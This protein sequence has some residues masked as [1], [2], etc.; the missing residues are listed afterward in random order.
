MDI[1]I[2]T[3]KWGTKYGP[4]YTNRLFHSLVSHIDVPF[5]FTCITDDARGLEQK[6]QIIDYNTWDPFDYPKD[7]V[8]TREKVVL[9]DRMT[10][11]NNFWIDQDILIHNNITDLVTRQLDVPTFI[12]NYWNW[13]HKTE[14]DRLKWF[15]KLTQCYVNSSFVGWTGDAGQFIFD[16]LQENQKEAFHIFKSLDKYLFY[17]HWRRDTIKFWERGLWY[18]YNFS[19]PAFTKQDSFKGCI[20]NTSHIKANSLDQKAFEIH[21]AEGW[22]KDMWQ[23]YDQIN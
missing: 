6:I 1:N 14:F 10:T 11:G 21:E 5:N 19:E 13:D 3:F 18:N 4:E 20:F 15:G 2:F 9:F 7:R 8:F 12:W 22:A 16:H 23:D 17:Q